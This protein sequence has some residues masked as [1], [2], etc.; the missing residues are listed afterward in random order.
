MHTSFALFFPRLL[1]IITPEYIP[2]VEDV[3]LARVRTTGI[4]E[5]EFLMQGRN[6]KIVDVGGQ[7]NERRK[8]MH[9]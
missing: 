6:F 1:E 2:S 5:E 8:W 9:W 4:V 7:R 3:L